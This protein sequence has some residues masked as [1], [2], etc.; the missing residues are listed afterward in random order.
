MA[1]IKSKNI[2]FTHFI[3]CFTSVIINK[4]THYFRISNVAFFFR[5]LLFG[6]NV[7]LLTSSYFWRTMYEREGV[8]SVTVYG[9]NICFMSVVLF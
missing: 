5:F 2:S 9:L 7:N 4:M 8:F 6:S 1:G 3:N